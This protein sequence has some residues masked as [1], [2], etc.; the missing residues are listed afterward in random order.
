MNL[1]AFLCFLVSSYS[2][3]AA[4]ECGINIS[5]SNIH[6]NWAGSDQVV[7]GTVTLTRTN[8]ANK[9]RPWLIGFGKGSSADY[10]N[11]KMFNATEYLSYNLFKNSNSNDP[12]RLINDVTRNRHRLLI[13]FSKNGMS[14]SGNFEARMAIPN[15]GREFL[16]KGTYFDTVTVEAVS[17][18]NNVNFGGQTSAT[19]QCIMPTEIDISL[20]D[21]GAAFN[22]SDTNQVLNFGT[23]TQGDSQSFDILARSNAGYAIYFSSQNNGK[24]K[25]LSENESIDYSVIAGGSTINLGSSQSTPALIAQATGVTSEDG[26]R[27]PIEVT[28]GN[29]QSKLQGQY[30]DLITITV[31]ST[32]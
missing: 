32:D 14:K 13:R 17:N 31:M 28:M 5:V 12:L 4:T 21:T 30:Q 10:Q 24:L 23:L 19:I 7:T 18:N 27:I 2:V 16:K 11:R 1:I 25:H 22:L 9:C 15:D 29:P 20:V 26:A 8:N 6:F 3:F